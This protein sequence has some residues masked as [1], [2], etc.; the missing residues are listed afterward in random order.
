MSVTDSEKYRLAQESR[1]LLREAIQACMDGSV[2]KLETSLNKFLT[3]HPNYSPDDFIIGFQSEGRTLLHIAASSGKESI[4][5][6]ISSTCKRLKDHV[7][8]NDNQGFTPLIYA[9]IAEA[10]SI[11]KTL[12]DLGADPYLRNKDGAAAVHFAAGDGNVHRMRVLL[13]LPIASN[14]ALCVNA[15]S[16]ECCW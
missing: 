13:D 6:Y 3:A 2:P 12:L 16:P 15:A 8:L 4:F 7:N 10:D 11:I 9:T 14:G 5:D 1:D